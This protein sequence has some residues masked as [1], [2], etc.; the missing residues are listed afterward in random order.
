MNVLSFDG[1]LI[2]ELGVL[3]VGTLIVIFWFLTRLPSPRQVKGCAHIWVAV[4]GEHEGM[5]EEAKFEKLVAPFLHHKCAKCGQETE[6]E[7]FF[8]TPYGNS[9]RRE[10]VLKDEEKGGVP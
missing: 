5:I 6:D 1:L 10:W 4:G 2:W 7:Q 8:C 3:V 9:S